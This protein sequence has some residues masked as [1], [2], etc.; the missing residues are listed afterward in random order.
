MD[1]ILAANFMLFHDVVRE[2][3]YDLWIGDE[4]WEL[5]YYLHENPEL[6][7]A[8]YV[9]MTDFVGWLPIDDSP[10]SREAFVAADYN[11]ENIHH[12]ERYPYVRD[13][14]VFV[15]AKEDVVPRHFG[16]E[17]PFMPDWIER[18]FDFPGYVLPFDPAEFED[19]E[20]LRQELGHDPAVGLVH[21]H[22][23][24]QRMR[25]QPAD[26]VVE[27]D[28]GLVAGRF[29][30]EHAHQL[31]RRDPDCTSAASD[32]S[33][34]ARAM[35]CSVTIAVTYLAGVTSN[36]GLRIRAPAGVRR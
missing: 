33:Y 14:A 22:L 9:F 27:R 4:A 10:G 7:T 23:R 24:M 29:D 30:A 3:R 2:Q 15:G 20:R 34:G 21:R 18:H 28:S 36:A 17:L 8:P 6:K 32:A 25:E 11:D 13:A 5:D 35:P 16:P 31:A 12:V 26:G 19:T 1:E